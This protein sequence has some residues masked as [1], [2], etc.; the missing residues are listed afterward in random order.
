MHQVAEVSLRYKTEVAYDERPKISTP[1]EAETYLRTIFDEEVLELHEV[2]IIV[3]LNAARRV[4]GW[5]QISQGTKNATL[6]DT[7][8][9]AQVVL[10]GNATSVVLAHNHPSGKLQESASDLNLT[11]RLMKGLK[12]FQISVD[13][14]II[15]TKDSY[16]SFR[17]EGLMKES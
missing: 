11:V 7:A 5:S 16:L 2:F 13:D 4:L 9:V 1:V 17:E 10:L 15:L 3:M 12:L 8:S 6:V 14:H